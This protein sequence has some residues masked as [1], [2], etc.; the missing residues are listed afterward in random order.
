MLSTS[1]Y[2]ES[3]SSQ[4]LAEMES[5]GRRQSDGGV[6]CSGGQGRLSVEVAFEQ[7]PHSGEGEKQAD[8]S[9]GRGGKG[10]GSRY[11]RLRGAA[12]FKVQDRDPR[13]RTGG[14]RGSGHEATQ[15][16]VALSVTK[17]KLFPN[18]GGMGVMSPTTTVVGES[19]EA[20]ESPTRSKRSGT[21][22]PSPVPPP[23]VPLPGPSFLHPLYL[24]PARHA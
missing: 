15:D 22:G 14:Q 16:Q 18:R 6:G 3:G 5:G 9:P 7:R 24:C 12:A 1:K 13:G 4:C 19:D 17:G 8:G 2:K 23:R 21:S 11:Q 20:T 10:Q